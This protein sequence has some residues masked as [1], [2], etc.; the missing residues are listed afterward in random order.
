M[1]SNPSACLP[2]HPETTVQESALRA[3]EK[4]GVTFPCHAGTMERAGSAAL[5]LAACLWTPAPAHAAPAFAAEL[6]DM[7]FEQLANIR[8]TSVSKK[9]E[10]LADA[11]AS[12]FVITAEAI[13]S[14]GVASLPEALRLAPNLH[15]AQTS[16]GSYGI[17]ARGFNGSN[18][19]AA[20]KLLVLIDGRS[21]Y[22]PLFSGV[23]WDVQD[24][25]L[26][27]VERI[28]V[29]SGPGGT[30]W[31]TNAVNGVINV[32]TRSASE[33]RGALVAAGAGSRGS[34]TA[35]RY[36]GALGEGGA[37]R[38]YGKYVERKH[39]STQ[40]G[41]AVD[42]GLYRTELGFRADWDGSGNR[43]TVQGNAYSGAVGQPAPG[44]ISISGVDLALGA[45]SVSGAN[46]TAGWTRLLDGGATVSVQAYYDRTM[47]T[48]PPT[49]SETLD[50]VDVQL[51]HSL[52]PSGAHALVWGA[53]LRYSMDRVVNS[54][55]FA[56]LP[57]KVDQTWASLFA[58]D[59]VSLRRDLALTVGARLEHNGYT[60][61]EFLPSV[62]LAWKL[63]PEHLLWSAAARA[64]RAP[65]RLDSDAFIPGKA[66]FLLD[67]GAAVRSEVAQVYELGYRG[68]AAASLTW[69]VTAFHAV[70][71]DLSTTEI[72]P[73]GTYL[74]FGNGMQ[75]TAN[76][77][78][79]WGTYQALPS[80]RL[81]AGLTALRERL[82]LK[83]SS[84]DS[85]G[86]NAAG[87]DPAHTWQLRSSWSGRGNG[88]TDVSVRH[89]AALSAVPAYTTLD[90][91]FGWKL[92]PG[93]DLSVIGQ[94]LFGRHAEYGAAV[95][96]AV[97]TPGVLVKL[98]WR[99]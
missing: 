3:G 1:F 20:N 10:R 78:E 22:T 81:S 62:R 96:R 49:F 11:A 91:R 90:A 60:G 74:T 82:W 41:G 80:W 36:G 15:V 25:P 26:E 29:I 27:D 38:V 45:I 47:R 52:A 70:Y 73:S 66:P 18:T 77:I 63:A 23:F 48:V 19:S 33:T 65:S 28:E 2:V 35:F 86:P 61:L 43:F 94:N 7:S 56:F 84:N 16:N 17:S 40:D 39:T 85:A 4:P 50:I 76:G 57:A 54:D 72:A 68:Q 9:A 46:V 55:Y 13:R 30:L 75:G 34:D 6:A 53:N 69:S 58:Q 92:R 5:I 95:N 97:I 64:V 8:I 14:A 93:L 24:V 31:G 12:V 71:S 32:I 59:V 99:Y 67:G 51:Q 42:D 37:Y 87:N 79:A 44:A 21:V 83:P 88:E 89:V 98:A